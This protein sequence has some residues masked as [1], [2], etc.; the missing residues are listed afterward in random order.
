M[1]NRTNDKALA[2]HWLGEGFCIFA[3]P[4]REDSNPRPA[5]P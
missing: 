3:W 2:E 1:Q 4:A 5:H